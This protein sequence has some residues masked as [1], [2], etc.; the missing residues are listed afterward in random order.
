MSPASA[1]TKS[2]P[3]DLTRFVVTVPYTLPNGMPDLQWFVVDAADEATAMGWFQIKF[4]DEEWVTDILLKD[5][6]GPKAASSCLIGA[7]TVVP[8]DGLAGVGKPWAT[9]EG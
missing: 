6:E 5:V 9:I 2:P 8:L 4:T 7:M 3:H 1:A